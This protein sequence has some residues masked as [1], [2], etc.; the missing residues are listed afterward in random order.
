MK[1]KTP[2]TG[3]EKLVLVEGPMW[4]D[5]NFYGNWLLAAARANEIVM[6]LRS[7][8]R[9]FRDVLNTLEVI[10]CVDFG[11]AATVFLSKLT[12]DSALHTFTIDPNS[13]E[14]NEFVLMLEMGFFTITGERYQMALPSKLDLEVVTRACCKLANTEDEEWI[15]PEHLA[16][17]M[18]SSRAKTFQCLLG[19][20]HQG[21]RL[22]DRGALLF[23]D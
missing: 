15:H 2:T 17:Q 5:A 7:T 16:V 23:L 21:Q 1:S 20:M 6:G 12:S 8:D 18:P 4:G 3:G 22:A 11:I 13:E 9:E 19:S 14:L 10:C